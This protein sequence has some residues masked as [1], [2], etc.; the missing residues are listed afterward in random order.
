MQH[1]PS[2]NSNL[3]SPSEIKTRK[4]LLVFISKLFPNS[5]LEYREYSETEPPSLDSIQGELVYGNG[6][7][8]SLIDYSIDISY[9]NEMPEVQDFANSVIELTNYFDPD[10]TRFYLLQTGLFI[11]NLNY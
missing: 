8:D 3:P 4:Q 6:P 7:D 11:C 9:Q 2:Q 1:T 10:F 5:H